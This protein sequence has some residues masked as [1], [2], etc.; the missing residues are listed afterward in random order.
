M[1]KTNPRLGKGLGAI[2]GKPPQAAASASGPATGGDASAGQI[3]SLPIDA[4]IPNRHQP[5]TRFDDTALGE[6]S[7]SIRA[8]GVLQPVIVRR[9]D[10]DRYEL[11]AGERRWRAARQAGLDHVPALVREAGESEALELALVE[12][13]Q[14]Q[15]LNPIERATAYRQYL[16]TFG[17]TAESLARRLGESRANVSNYLRLLSL[18]EEIRQMVESGDLSMGHARALLSAEDEQRQLTIARMAVR[19]NLSVRQVEA[20]CKPNDAREAEAESESGEAASRSQHL[21]DVETSLSKALGLRV[22]IKPGKRKNTGRVVIP[23]ANLEQFDLI[24]ERISGR[25]TLE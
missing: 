25:S 1:S 5:R 19:R 9:L 3:R 16:D 23:Y 8:N 4:V 14:R 10:G 21:A 11:I 15:D 17:G 7:A 18:P 13:L 22:H 6:L 12:N 20:A 2:L 24:A